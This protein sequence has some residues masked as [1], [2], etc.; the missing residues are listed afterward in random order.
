MSHTPDIDPDMIDR[1]TFDLTMSY[2]VPPRLLSKMQYIPEP[3]DYV[4]H[5]PRIMELIEAI[6]IA[7]ALSPEDPILPTNVPQSL[8]LGFT[9]FIRECNDYFQK[10]ERL[11][12]E[13]GEPV[14]VPVLPAMS[15]DAQLALLHTK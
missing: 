13:S 11:S 4:T 12:R 6:F 9:E 5:K 1:D 8:F 15:L 3:I 10:H 2:L 7:G 14:S